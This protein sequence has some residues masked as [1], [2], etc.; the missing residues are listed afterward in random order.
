[1]TIDYYVQFPCKVRGQTSDADLL[2]MEK[3]RNRA[4]LV[5]ETMRQDGKKRD[6]PESEWTL[7]VNVMGPQGLQTSEL[8]VSDMLAEAAPLQALAQ[9]CRGCPANLQQ[10]DFGCGGAIRYPIQPATEQW[11]LSRLP[12][13]LKS[14]RG[15]LLMNAIKDLGYDGT[16]VD[17]S[18]KELYVNDAPVQRS[19]GGWL[20][21]KTVT[22]SQALQMLFFVGSLQPAHAKM[23][24]FFFGFTDGAMRPR[25]GGE[26][27]AR[28]GD[29]RGIAEFKQFLNAA[30]YAGQNEVG[31][32]I[33][34]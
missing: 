14:A 33:D 17:R 21:K 29:P 8:K 23:V 18:R 10:R 11:L 4:R 3:A 12:D 2:R 28:D 31:L 20:S 26:N 25:P 24:S 7:T 9:H 5:L 16:G 13:D 27:E 6:E 34:S 30:A 15:N 19:W 22:S 32:M 1:M